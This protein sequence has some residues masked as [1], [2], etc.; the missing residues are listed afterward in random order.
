MDQTEKRSTGT[1]TCADCG[2]VLRVFHDPHCF[3]LVY[4]IRDWRRACTRVYL[5]D[6]AW[7]LVQREGASKLAPPDARGH[8]RGNGLHCLDC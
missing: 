8:E 5:G 1:I 4:D 3:K 6:A 2:L 7:C